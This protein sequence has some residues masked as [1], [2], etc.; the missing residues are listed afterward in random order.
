VVQV[1]F[2]HFFEPTRNKT[3]YM[4]TKLELIELGYPEGAL[5]EEIWARVLQHQQSGITQR[6]YL[7]KLLRREFGAPDGRMKMR[8][9]PLPFG[10]AIKETCEDGK[11]NIAAVTAKMNELLCT[12]IIEAGAVMPDA[13]PAS[14]GEAVIPVGGAIAVNNAI[15]PSAHSA[16]ICCS[17]YATF[18]EARTSVTN[19]MNALA[20]STRF[21]PG[22]RHYDHLVHHPVVDEPVWD[23]K[24]L[25]GLQDYAKVHMADQGDG[26]HFAYIGK[27]T[28]TVAQLTQLREA[29]FHQIAE[30]LAESPTKE[31]RVL[32][33]HHGSRGLGSH[34]YKRGQKAA[35]KNTAKVAEGVP[36]A[37]AWIDFDS[38][39]G[40]AYWEA[41]QYV[42]RWTQANHQS[43]HQRFLDSIGA[44]EVA[45]M[46]NEHNFV[47]RRQGENGENIFLHGKGATPAWMDE[48][49]H[50]QL[51][52]VPMNMGAPI[53]IILGRDN[54]DYLGFAPHGAGRNLSRTA[55]KRRFYKSA[56]DPKAMQVAIDQATQGLDIRWYCGKPDLSESPI[57][58]K[59][60]DQ[61]KAQI[62]EFGL[63]DIVAEIQPLGSIM[64]GQS[65]IPYWQQK[66]EQLTPKQRRQLQHRA[67]RRTFKQQLGQYDDESF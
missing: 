27:V 21:G 33:T 39:E 10:K 9:R 26:N 51:G 60:A 3:I 8:K 62:E 7:L 42:S 32:V 52:L 44:S 67:E 4:I 20:T 6:K 63:A 61:V 15:I 29:G 12:P 38:K 28:F 65:A 56:S 17:M 19:E 25:S 24:F 1:G 66:E 59:N 37:A 64:A 48:S 50:P 14:M 55:L 36:Q 30:A 13:C 35:E 11:K 22:G 31:Y 49:G 16:D 45:T 23:N 53:L 40:K 46:G 18:Y 47:W 34:L 43:I 57:A 2:G 54:Q 5:I 41:L 58:Y